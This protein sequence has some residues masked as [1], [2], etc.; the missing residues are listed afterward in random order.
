[1][2]TEIFG[3]IDKIEVNRLHK[4]NQKSARKLIFH[5]CFTF[6]CVQQI[7]FRDSSRQI[8]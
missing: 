7:I 4:N 6:S 1:M 8:F 3:F 5:N 2:I